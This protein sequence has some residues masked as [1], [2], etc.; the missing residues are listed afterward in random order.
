MHGA[1]KV[2]DPV[3]NNLVNFIEMFQDKGQTC[4]VFERLDMDLYR[5]V[6]QQQRP[7]TLC[8]I[9]PIAYQSAPEV[10]L[11][12]PFSKAIDMWSFGCLHSKIREC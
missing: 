2:L 10:S 8:E 3:K 9:R 5:L 12:L 4:L 11:G 1:V 7:M 6:W